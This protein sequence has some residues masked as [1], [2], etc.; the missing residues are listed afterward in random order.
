MVT[1][2]MSCAVTVM[3]ISIAM[4]QRYEKIQY[5]GEVYTCQ[6]LSSQEM[7]PEEIARGIQK[8]NQVEYWNAVSWMIFPPEFLDTSYDQWVYGAVPYS[9]V[10]EA[11]E[12]AGMEFPY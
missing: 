8:E 2:L 1:V 7:D 4:K 12:K 11:A 3:A 10:K 9:Q 6:V 5:F